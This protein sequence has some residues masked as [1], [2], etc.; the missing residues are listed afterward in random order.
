MN[1]GINENKNVILSYVYS[2]L[3]F[4]FATIIW[5]SL[6]KRDASYKDLTAFC[7]SF[8]VEGYMK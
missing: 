4:G 8:T 5:A 7:Q 6:G 3:I 1:I 2:G